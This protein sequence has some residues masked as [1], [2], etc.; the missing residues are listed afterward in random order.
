MWPS[1][2][3]IVPRSERSP[4]QSLVRAHAWVVGQIPSWGGGGMGEATDRCLSHMSMFLSLP[5]SLL[6]LLSK[7]KYVKC[8]K[9]KTIN[10]WKYFTLLELDVR[11]AL[12]NQAAVCANNSLRTNGISYVP[13]LS[14]FSLICLIK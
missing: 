13:V 5:F 7:N 14:A 4:V 12:L 3:D 9:K 6:Y 1:G 10:I 8:F 11:E 2:L